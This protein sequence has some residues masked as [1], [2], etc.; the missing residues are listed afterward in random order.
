M[1]FTPFLVTLKINHPKIDLKKIEEDLVQIL[2]EK[3]QFE[4]T[5]IS[6]D[7]IELRNAKS[8]LINCKFTDSYFEIDSAASDEDLEIKNIIDIVLNISK[9]KRISIMEL[10]FVAVLRIE[11]KKKLLNFNL[12][13]YMPEQ[14]RIS[15]TIPSE[16]GSEI[17]IAI[18]DNRKN[19]DNQFV[20]VTLNSPKEIYSHNEFVEFFE[21]QKQGMILLVED[22]LKPQED[23][24]RYIYDS[25]V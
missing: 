24:I 5:E 11:E 23:N 22:T 8:H 18:M 3:Y 16:E 9:I 7:F 20:L 10:E 12:D 4:E 19:I 1:K 21:K 6:P 13:K 2:K 17:K 14:Y 15:F 25:E